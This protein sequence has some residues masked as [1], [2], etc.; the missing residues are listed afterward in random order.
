M[1]RTTAVAILV[2]VS[3]IAFGQATTAERAPDTM[4][5]RVLAC[6]ACHGKDG[7][8]T[9]NDYFPRLAGKPA[10]YLYNQLLAF[11]DGR[12]QY[13]PM[14]YLLAYL[15]DAYLKTIAEHFARQRPPYP[16]ASTPAVSAQLLQRG[17]RLVKE[18]D[19]A[20]NI[21]ACTACHGAALTGVDPAIPGL[22]GLHASY[23]SA[24]LGAWRYGTR[25]AIAPD[26]MHDVA[27]RLSNDDIT[28]VAAWLAAS[29]GPANPVSAPARSVKLPIACGSEPQ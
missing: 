18:G 19:P 22:L 8:G 26:C 16:P 29:P 12:R 2:C 4:Q 20:R 5:A 25:T 3:N 15:P 9:D 27:S 13:P 28:A 21:P 11:R 1:L 14:N 10:G 24:Q 23:I 6:A 17:E 7:E